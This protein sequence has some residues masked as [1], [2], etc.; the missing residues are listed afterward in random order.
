MF[1]KQVETTRLKNTS[2][3]KYNL[4]IFSV[5]GRYEHWVGIQ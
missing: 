4:I 2:I 3:N 5:S 1:N